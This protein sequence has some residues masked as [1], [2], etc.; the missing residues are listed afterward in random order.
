VEYAH[1][2]RGGGGIIA[3][4]GAEL[5]DSRLPF[6]MLFGLS[7]IG[8]EAYG[9]WFSLPPG[10]IDGT[11]SVEGSLRGNLRPSGSGWKE[12]HGAFSLYSD[13]GTIRRYELLSKTLTLIN[14]T[15]WARVRLSDLYAR[16]LPYRQIQGTLRLHKG[17][18]ST[19]DLV[20]DTSIARVTLRGGYDVV[21]DRM[22]AEVTLQ[23]M[24][25]LDLVL[26]YLPV[27]GRVIS[28]PDGTVVV[29]HYALHGPL[30]DLSIELIPLKS[31]NNRI[32]APFKRLNRWWQ[33]LEERRP[34]RDAP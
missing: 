10:F 32:G 23:P 16:G 5:R 24:E 2:K 20:L 30:K 3:Q 17:V 29:F 34:F 13:G 25:Q 31:L 1:G 18:L 21:H 33:Y 9:S 26:D 7:Q 6:S 4:G 27:L 11:A 15:Q 14:F 28:G 12:I 19:E 8:T 22:D